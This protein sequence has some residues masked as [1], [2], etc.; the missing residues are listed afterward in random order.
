MSD[1]FTEKNTGTEETKLLVE[2]PSKSET[3]M[4]ST[5]PLLHNEKARVDIV[6]EGR[7]GDSSN[8]YRKP[9]MRISKSVDYERLPQ[10]DPSISPPVAVKKRSQSA[11][12]DSKSDPVPKS[13]ISNEK[14]AWKAG[15]NKKSVRPHL[16]VSLLRPHSDGSLRGDFL[17]KDAIKQVDIQHYG[18]A[19]AAEQFGLPCRKL[20][21]RSASMRERHPTK[22]LLR[23]NSESAIQVNKL[24]RQRSLNNGY[25]CSG[26]I[27]CSNDDLKE[28]I[29]IAHN[30]KDGRREKPSMASIGRLMT[31][32]EFTPSEKENI[33]TRS[34]RANFERLGRS[35]EA[36]AATGMLESNQIFLS[37]STHGR[38]PTRQTSTI[39]NKTTPLT[40]VL[41]SSSNEHIFPNVIFEGSYESEE[42]VAV[43][44]LKP[45]SEVTDGERELP[46]H[47]ACETTLTEQTDDTNESQIDLGALSAFDP[48]LLGKAIEARLSEEISQ[49][50]SD[51]YDDEQIK[52]VK[53][54]NRIKR[55][56]KS[57]E[58]WVPN[59]EANTTGSKWQSLLTKLNLRKKDDVTDTGVKL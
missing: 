23:T 50:S 2:S 14:L 35:A 48:E 3:I 59:Q 9:K 44:E 45:I 20:D 24:V 12:F 49:Q 39:M 32:P 53:K 16:D 55:S 28:I 51:D 46:E 42:E 41:T 58:L 43:F 22:K 13:P 40:H 52:D 31:M 11:V 57:G 33:S 10:D 15:V 56:S 19:F 36:P 5:R 27:V 18:N 4:S 29:K 17:R 7:L 26:G 30:S 21:A 54:Q 47:Q 6:S 37:S 8:R 1:Q 38:S 25:P 34:T